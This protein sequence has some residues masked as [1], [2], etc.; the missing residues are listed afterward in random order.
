MAV[1]IVK[2]GNIVFKKYIGY[3]NLEHEIKIDENT[4]FNIA[5]N[6]KQYTA[7]CIL[8]LMRQGKLALD[9]DI[10]KY[11]PEL[12]K[13]IEYKIT[14]SNLLTHTSGIRDVYGLWALKGKDW[15]ELFIDN[16]DAIELLKSQTNL[17]FQPGK[18]Y[19]YS[20]SNYILLTKIIEKVTDTK[21]KDFSNSLFT[22]IGMENSSFLTNH[23]A[24]IPNKARPYGNWNGWREYP[25]IT[26]LN[27]DGGL[28]T[29]LEDQLKWEQT[30]KQNN[31]K[32]LSTSIIDKRQ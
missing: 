14:I 30:I 2:D 19:L 17:N 16:D 10:R 28:F 26:E 7:L 20:N 6:A 4:R 24:V 12:Y 5:S 27:G 8:R 13:E 21:F 25:T 23:M 32:T 15:Y 9:D 31:S 1:G 22:E 11:L 18:E 29:T 3:S